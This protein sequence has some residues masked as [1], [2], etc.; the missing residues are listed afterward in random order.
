MYNYLRKINLQT[1]YAIAQ[2][3]W[4]LIISTAHVSIIYGHTRFL[5]HIRNDIW[6]A[7]Y[8]MADGITLRRDT[9]NEKLS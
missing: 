7:T 3:N 6:D 8:D 4:G 2:I 5:T 9:K 1:G